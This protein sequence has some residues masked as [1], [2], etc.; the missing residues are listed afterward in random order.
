[1]P[2]LRPTP[3][4]VS[5]AGLAAIVLALT[6]C[7]DG[8]SGD[9]LRLG[10]AGPL[11][12]FIGSH[13]LRGTELARDELNA[14]GGVRGRRVEIVALS[15]SANAG[16]A[17]TVADG[18]YSDASVSA[19]VGH[20][21]SGATLAAAPIYNRGLP[22]VSPVATSPEISDAGA[23][24]FRVCSSDDANAAGLAEFALREL[25]SRAAIIYANDPYGRGLRDGFGRTFTGGGAALVGEYPF[26]EGETT[27]F[28]AYLVAIRNAQPDFIFIGST[29]VGA[30]LVIRQARELGIEA[31]F[32]GGDGILGLA[33]QHSA[34]EG[35][36]IGLLYHPDAPGTGGAEFVAAYRSR[37]GEPPDHFAA[38]GYDAVM[39]VAQAV[40]EVGFERAKIRDYLEQVGRERDAFRGVT[41]LIAF[42]ANG[43]P[44]EKSFA[45][46]R[47]SGDRIE[48]VS[49][50]GGS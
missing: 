46:G 32:L 21:N 15:D 1:M 42:D 37:Y 30:G 4:H 39:L 43:D 19:V 34:Y 8:G 35:T 23:W 11:E 20:V 16:R 29:D 5:F 12:Q 22:T 50:E 36:Y 38:L 18:L 49:E 44:V 33:G 27:D 13:T 40:A 31:P 14:A 17:V 9:S 24:I 47:I 3:T 28:Q 10:V 6:A 25:G 48:F 41:G 26:I 7:G 45:V 2:S